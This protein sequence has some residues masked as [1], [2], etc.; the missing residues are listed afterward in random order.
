MVNFK[1]HIF[2]CGKKRQNTDSWY[3]RL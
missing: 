1:I 2:I 3:P